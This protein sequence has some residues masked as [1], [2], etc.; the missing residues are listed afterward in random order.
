MCNMSV[1]TATAALHLVTK[2]TSAQGAL[3]GAITKGRMGASCHEGRHMA[4]AAN[5][6]IPQ[7]ML[8]LQKPV[9]WGAQG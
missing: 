6:V 7:Q 5:T 1:S 9:Q 2:G 4:A 3:D 8:M